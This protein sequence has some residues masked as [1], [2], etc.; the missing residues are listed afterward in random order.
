M[1]FVIHDPV[2][3][4]GL[5]QESQEDRNKITWSPPFKGCFFSLHQMGPETRPHCKAEQFWA[6]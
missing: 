1:S 2:F 3:R 5:F 4:K 6:G